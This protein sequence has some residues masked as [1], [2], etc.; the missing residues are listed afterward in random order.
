MEVADIT[1]LGTPTSPPVPILMVEDNRSDVRLL[2][3]AFIERGMA[4]RLLVAST[5]TEVYGFM[6]LLPAAER[7]R[8]V[9]ADLS[10][11]IASGHEV[12][13]MLASDPRWQAI[14]KVV[15]SSSDR[16]EDLAA[17][18]AVG[19]VAHLV[20]P[21][22]FDGMLLIADRIRELLAATAKV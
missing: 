20:K 1:P 21:A 8:L 15:L 6:R 4:L 10:L 7:P 19:A 3:E 18:Q 13:R 2:T 5:I 16:A 11:P 22:C 17:S 9:I 14:P 12:L